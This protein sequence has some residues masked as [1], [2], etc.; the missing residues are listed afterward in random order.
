MPARSGL[1]NRIGLRFY[2]KIKGRPDF[3]KKSPAQTRLASSAGNSGAPVRGRAFNSFRPG[4]RHLTR[5]NLN[6]SG[7]AYSC[8]NAIILSAVIVSVEHSFVT[9]RCFHIVCRSANWNLLVS[10]R[11]NHC[12]HIDSFI[13]V[14]VA[15]WSDSAL[16]CR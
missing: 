13:L 15:V 3:S 10:K 16:I 1:K 8:R 6:R 12:C 7:N 4:I 14:F 9:V 11:A 5:A 2:E